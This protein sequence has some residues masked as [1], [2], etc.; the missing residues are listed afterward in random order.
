MADYYLNHDMGDDAD[1]GTQQEPW[2]TF[3]RA[4]GN[5]TYTGAQ[6]GDTVYCCSGASAEVLSAAVNNAYASN[7]NTTSGAVNFIGC[8]AVWTP[9]AAQY[10]LDGNASFRCMNY[11]TNLKAQWHHL[12]YFTFRNAVSDGVYLNSTCHYMRFYRCIF[13]NNATYGLRAQQTPHSISAIHCIARNNTTVG[14]GMGS[15]RHTAAFCKVHG[16]GSHGLELLYNNSTMLVHGCLIYENFHAGMRVANLVAAW[17]LSNTIH[18]NGVPTTSSGMRIEIGHPMLILGNRIT[19]NGGWGIELDGAL[20]QENWVEDYNVF[21]A[22]GLGTIGPAGAT[23]GTFGHSIYNPAES[24]YVDP[25]N[26][27]Y[28]LKEDAVLRRTAIDLDWA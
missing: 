14:L 19:N 12:Q 25:G 5:A 4:V 27:D 3:Q 23:L 21:Y 9:G 6:A 13:E 20:K 7:G 16:N 10:V 11:A 22:N 26:D 15:Y 1:P 24:G 17:L 28:N 2:K 8:N 18:S